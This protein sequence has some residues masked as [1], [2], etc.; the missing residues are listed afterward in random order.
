MVEHLK[1]ETHLRYS[2]DLQVN[3]EVTEKLE[4]EEKYVAF[5]RWCDENDIVHP[6]V[7]YPVAFGPTGGLVGVVATREIG[8]GE[9]YVYVPLKCIISESK[10]RADPQ[11]GHLLDKY[12]EL[13]R[14]R[15]NSEHLVV[16]FFCLHE[17][18][19]GEGSFWYH[20]FQVSA[21]S[22][23]PAQWSDADLDVL[24]DPIMKLEMK[25][26]NEEL[27]EEFEEVLEMA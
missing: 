4:K 3:W 19:K 21:L 17:M 20:Y 26:E 23:M 13:F 9:A 27:E 18:S 12:P 11:I 5:N 25:D 2:S 7:R 1:R 10:F 14:D 8:I 6:A 16:I 22:E 15:D 24:H